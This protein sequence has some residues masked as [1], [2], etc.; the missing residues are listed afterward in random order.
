M[1]GMRQ[2][3]SSERMIVQKHIAPDRRIILAV[4]DTELLGK[5]IEEK[6]RQLDLAGSFYRGE[7]LGKDAVISLMQRA[8]IINCVGEESVNCA[9][10][11]KFTSSENVCRISGVPYTQAVIVRD[12]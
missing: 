10:E 8:Y 6:G 11:A 1:H 12:E 2:Q 5:V 4:C 3:E 7:P 9:L